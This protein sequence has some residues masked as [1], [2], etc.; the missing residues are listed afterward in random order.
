VGKLE[1]FVA[2]GNDWELVGRCGEKFLTDVVYGEGGWIH[3]FAYSSDFGSGPLVLSE[4]ILNRIDSH[5]VF[6]PISKDNI[7]T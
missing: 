4:F 2:G 3:R 5:G 7:I 1:E 6:Q